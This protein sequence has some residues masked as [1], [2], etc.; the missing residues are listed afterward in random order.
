MLLLRPLP[1]PAGNGGGKRMDKL[2]DNPWVMR[3]IAL[4]LALMLYV[5]VNIDQTTSSTSQ[6]LGFFGD[7]PTSDETIV[8]DIPVVTYF[9]QD[10]LVVT[11]IPET[12]SVTLEGSTSAITKASKLKDFEVYADLTNLSLGTHNVRLKTKNLANDLTASVNPKVI[13]VTLEEKITKSFTVDVDFLNEDKL[14]EGYTPDQPIVNPNS[15]NITASK[16][17]IDRIDSV[18]S[19]IN[20]EDA[21]E[22]V[23]QDARITVYDK[24]GNA[25][26]VEVEPSVVDVTVPIKSPSKALPFKITREGELGAGLSILSLEPD[27]N[28]ITVYG[29]LSVLEQLEVIDGVKVDLSKIKE[30][31]IIEIDVPKPDGVNKVVPEKINIKVDV[32]EQEEK[33]FSAKVINEVGLS[34]GK[35]FDFIDPDSGALDVTIYGAPSI[36]QDINEDD[37]ELYVNLSDLN[38]GEHEVD[39]QVNGPQNITWTLEKKQVKVKISSAS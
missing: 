36:I 27:P 17:I 6:P 5:S 10:N 37:I 35:Q 22:T 4:F 25:L 15:I 9:D 29:P 23:T 32:E 13:T 21:K 12:V 11:G 24:D 34:E 3:S 14:E 38:D 1:Q 31:S 8:T 2:I 30:D 19:T 28:E 7:S 20:L 39:V 26:P 16:E 33:E 18:K